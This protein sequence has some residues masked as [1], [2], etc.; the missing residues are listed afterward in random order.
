MQKKLTIVGPVL[1]FSD[2]NPVIVAQI[3]FF[4]K[5]IIVDVAV[6]VVNVKVAVAVAVR[7]GAVEGAAE[8]EVEV[9]LVVQSPHFRRPGAGVT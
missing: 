5:S 7:A 2:E 3:I 6:V 1:D 4:V 8:G 9:A